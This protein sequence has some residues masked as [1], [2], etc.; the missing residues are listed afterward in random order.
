[1]YAEIYFK[2]KIQKLAFITNFKI[3]FST[4]FIVYFLIGIIFAIA[5]H[6]TEI[7]D[8]PILVTPLAPNAIQNAHNV[9][10]VSLHI[11]NFTAFE[12]KE[13]E[14]ISNITL[15][16]SYNKNFEHKEYIDT[17]TIENAT[18]I[19]KSTAQ[20]E[21]QANERVITKYNLNVKSNNIFNF[22]YF[23]F[24]RHNVN[25]IITNK[26]AGPDKIIYTTKN[27]DFEINEP[28]FTKNW[29]I[30][31]QSVDYGINQQSI[32]SYSSRAVFSLAIKRSS[33]KEPLIIFLPLFLIFFIGLLSLTF[34]VIKQFSTILTLSIGSTS[35]LIF[36][37]RE[38]RLT[39][40]TTGSFTSVEMVYL[41][42][43]I[44]ILITLTVQVIMLQHLHKKQSITQIQEILDR[45]GSNFNT[46]RGL[47]FV[48]L[49][50]IMLS[51]ITLVLLS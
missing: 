18:I 12:V 19:D 22:R 15:Y 8:P 48:I 27:V 46:I 28:I 38:L 13:N 51:L 30:Y 39:L 21:I 24:D 11:N 44:I 25:F 42:T 23:P 5:L 7:V 9:V 10:E 49:P 32:K 29:T 43:I 35:A 1:M 6:K 17:F 26:K 3:L 50:F 45:T 41:L 33:Y 47:L 31:N 20:H 34:N 2:K 16:F 14:F 36:Y 4:L 37:S 40:P